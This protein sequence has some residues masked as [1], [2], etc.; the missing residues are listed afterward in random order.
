MGKDFRHVKM[1][2]FLAEGTHLDGELTVKGGIRIDGEVKGKI[3]S[4]SVVFLGD[5]ARVKADIHAE[6][7]VSSGQVQGSIHS[8][9]QVQ[10]TNPGSIKG[11]IETREL[12]LEKGV[13]F[14][15]FCKIIEPKK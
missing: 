6:A 5:S 10:V 14:D 4:E 11:S 3:K 7:V 2:S 1:T 8:T 13:F 15:G 12:V 9:R